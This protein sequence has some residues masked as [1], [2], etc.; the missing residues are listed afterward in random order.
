MEESE[1]VHTWP[2]QDS[3]EICMYTREFVLYTTSLSENIKI[4]PT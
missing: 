4:H 3:F 2:L 1:K